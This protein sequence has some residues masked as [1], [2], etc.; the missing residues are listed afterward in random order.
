M[1]ADAATAEPRPMLKLSKASR[2]L[3]IPESTLRRLCAKGRVPAVKVGRGWRVNGAW[4]ESE[5]AWPREAT[6]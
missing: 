1:S 2:L 3:D 6:P 5:A 4:V